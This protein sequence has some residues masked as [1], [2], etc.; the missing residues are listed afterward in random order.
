MDFSSF[1]RSCQEWLDFVAADPSAAQDG[2]AGNDISRAGTL[3]ET[4]NKA[5]S[6]AGAKRIAAEGLEQRVE[7]ST[8]QIPAE[9]RTIPLR[10]YRPK[11][12]D[13]E[14]PNGAVLYFHGGGYLFGD[15]TTDDF[16]CS[17]I[18][19][20]TNTAVLSVVYRHTHKYKHPAQVDDAWET[21][22][23]IR[24][25]ANTV[26]PSISKGL[27]VMGISAG[28]TL[29]AGVVLRDL[30]VSRTQAGVT[31][32][33]TGAV[34]GIPWLVH[35]D[36]Y[37]MAFFKSPEV[38]AKI[39]NVNAPVIPYAR[40]EMFSRLLGADDPKERLLNIP[41]LTDGE[42]RGWPK[43]AFLIAGVDPLRD[44]GLIFARRL[45]TLK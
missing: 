28:C 42:L 18:A 14:A 6:A 23:Y 21:F 4:S 22:E 3:R 41:L 2:I 20:Q 32:K 35:I 27:V 8:H 31:S 17:S 1:G 25:N 7:I 24:D 15:E 30:E 19:D 34:F 36:N 11:C 45:E 29:A 5:R 16:L 9:S 39:Q 38:S 43:T 10:R 37:P 12:T 13:N 26:E 33:I 40:L 44:D